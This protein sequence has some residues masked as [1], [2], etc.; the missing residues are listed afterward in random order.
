MK[1][2]WTVMSAV[3]LFKPEHLWQTAASVSFESLPKTRCLHKDSYTFFYIYFFIICKKHQ[4]RFG[5]F[6]AVCTHRIGS[7]KLPSISFIVLFLLQNIFLAHQYCKHKIYIQ[8]W[9]PRA[10]GGAQPP[11]K[12]TQ[13]YRKQISPSKSQFTH[14]SFLL[15]KYTLTRQQIET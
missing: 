10:G 15:L 1:N 9:S 2:R 14:S 3:E 4:L 11:Q 13:P 5:G 7:C 6:N 8:P 12:I